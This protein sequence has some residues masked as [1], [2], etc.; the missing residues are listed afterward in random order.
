MKK[1]YV[2]LYVMLFESARVRARSSLQDLC[3][4]PRYACLRAPAAAGA[5]SAALAVDVL[6]DVL[7]GLEYLHGRAA[8]ARGCFTPTYHCIRA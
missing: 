6:L 1:L 2:K 8:R 5:L 4:S 7:M 3:Q